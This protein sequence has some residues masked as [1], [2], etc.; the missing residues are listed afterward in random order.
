MKDKKTGDDFSHSQKSQG[1]ATN[2]EYRVRL[3]D[4]RMQIVSYTADENGYKADVRYDEDKTI[5]NVINNDRDYN[6]IPNNYNVNNKQHNDNVGYINH[7]SNNDYIDNN[8]IINNKV[9]ADY[10][11]NNGLQRNFKYNK[12]SPKDYNNNYDSREYF[13]EDYSS[14]YNTNYQ[15]YK[16]KYSQFIDNNKI[17]NSLGVV[18]S[19]IRPIYDGLKDQ[20]LTKNLYD[21]RL[22]YINVPSSTAKYLNYEPTTETVIIGT[23]PSFYANLKHNIPLFSPTPIT[24]TTPRSYLISTI[25]SLKNRIVQQP[26]LSNRFIDKINKYLNF[27]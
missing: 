26:V 19:T 7:N 15:P 22:N 4:G 20:Y 27:N 24:V 18:T 11:N 14:E 5:S 23:K 9:N 13:N 8:Y 1:S 17:S 10:N 21:A 6:V 2:G 3:P 12:E 25:A 16:S